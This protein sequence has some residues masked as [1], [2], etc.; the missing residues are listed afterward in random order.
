MHPI[1]PNS[2]SDSANRANAERANAERANAE[3][4]N[5][6]RANPEQTNPHLA[7]ARLRV[8][9]AFATFVLGLI[10]ARSLEGAL[11]STTWFGFAAACL[12]LA[13]ILPAQ[14]RASS[15]AQLLARASSACL[16]LA[17]LSLGAGWFTF[18]IHER[19]APTLHYTQGVVTVE[20]FI[21]AAPQWRAAQSPAFFATGSWRFDLALTSTLDPNNSARALSDR[22]IPA[23]GA[24]WVRL[25]GSHARSFSTDSLPIG[26]RV[27]I[28]GT[29][30][31]ID[32]P[33]N[34]GQSD[35]RLLAAQR[36]VIGSLSLS[37]PSLIQ[38]LAPPSRFTRAIQTALDALRRRA[39]DVVARAA[40]STQTSTPTSFET[41]TQAQNQPLS[42]SS[43]LSS[44]D[45]TRA[46]QRQA[47][48]TGLLLGEFD[49]ASQDVRDI[50]DAFA[51]QGLVHI[52]SIS[53]FHLTVLAGVSLALLRLT[54]DQ[55]RL[56]PL[57][58]AI[59]VFIFLLIVPAQSPILR[60]GLLVL[61]LL[62]IQATGRRYDRLIVLGWISIALLIWRP[63]DAWSIGYQLSVGL[64]AALLWRGH[65][66][67]ARLW[68]LF[69]PAPLKG[70]RPIDRGLLG[71]L[72]EAVKASLSTGL[73][74]GFFAFPIVAYHAGILSTLGIFVGIIVTPVIILALWIGYAALIVGMFIPP[75]AD[76]AASTLAALAEAAIALVQLFDRIPLSSTRLP[77]VPI[78]W[79][80]AAT[81][82]FAWWVGV[83]RPRRLHTSILI[84]LLSAW[85][86]IAWLAP[87]QLA[88]LSSASSAS[89]QP[90]LRIDAFAVGDATCILIR[91][92]DQALLWDAGGPTQ[93]GI[94]P[95]IVQWTRALDAWHV[96]SLIIT[97]ADIDHYAAADTIIGPLNIKRLYMS[98]A[99]QAQLAR[100]RV[101]VRDA[102]Y[103]QR[104]NLT[105]NQSASPLARIMDRATR[106]LAEN[107]GSINTLARGD[108][109]S[110]GRARFR[111][112][113]PPA[114]FDLDAT[115]S[116]DNDASLVAHIEVQTAAGP[117]H[118]L[119][120]GDIT[121][122]SIKLIRTFEPSLRAHIMEAPHH[123]TATPGVRD[124]IL[125]IAPDVVIQSAGKRKSS[126]PRL[127]IARQGRLWHATGIAGHSFAEIR[128]DG[129]IITGTHN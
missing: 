61:A 10:L 18:R 106:T 3:R 128:T 72:L 102:R 66:F 35:L 68:N 63:L 28:T 9:V 93:G 117:R 48:I 118:I 4:A 37:D 34:P 50:R 30:D 45:A 11:A 127:D 55:G 41:Q 12:L 101:R 92:D 99:M 82:A 98:N 104:S 13:V 19:A 97:H 44:I 40:S 47:L 77:P 52:L 17:A 54:G 67:H 71:L 121:D 24:L 69:S 23:R 16:A 100:D 85:L 129:S 1:V 86:T 49:P 95:D 124:W 39:A 27:R 64:T 73:L 81:L 107:K 62:L 76:F 94:L 80:F 21:T 15:R 7:H 60:S 2:A 31:T 114:D 78:F 87:N 103:V 96:Q 88:S 26:T 79:A 65:A 6:E 122:N 33:T 111:V 36:G 119:L 113:W 8:A 58:V 53:G 105:S 43:F 51:R 38:T 5:A 32:P 20:G 14:F 110:L 112:L 22:T 115:S 59:L 109:L 42:N 84:L 74:C 89:Q 56:E 125:D 57:I 123:G 116:I 25:P 91:S 90:L 120:T 108:E 70:V 29:I 75:A 83:H 46:T 126:D